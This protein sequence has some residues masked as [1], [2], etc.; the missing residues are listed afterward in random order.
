[1]KLENT[2][3][4]PAPPE[5]VWSFLLDV[6]KIAPCMPGAE[7]TEVVDENNWKGKVTVKLGPVS[8]A[9]SG[10]ATLTER[11]DANYRGVLTAK[12]S[13]MRGK[14]TASA[15]VTSTL[16]PTA[17]GGT[18]AV[19][20]TDVTL[21][22]AAAQYGRGMIGDVSQRLTD[23][24]ARCLAERLTSGDGEGSQAAADPVAGLRLGLWALFRAIGRFLSKI[25][26]AITGKR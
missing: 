5:Q 21:T 3:E 12:G 13:E 15:V 4:V 6:E 26:R 18:R 9:F 25:W 17:D 14:G 8:L 10:T 2:F 1:M 24:F 7:L 11:D 23:E 16:E 20:A 19:M 22:G